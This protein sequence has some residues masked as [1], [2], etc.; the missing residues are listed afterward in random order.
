MDHLELKWCDK[1][2]G[3]KAE[4]LISPSNVTSNELYL[5]ILTALSSNSLCG[6]L[7]MWNGINVKIVEEIY[8]KLFLKF[9]YA[10]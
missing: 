7:G 1:E 9:N 4:V 6:W 3:Q 2:P 5:P 8:L 10:I